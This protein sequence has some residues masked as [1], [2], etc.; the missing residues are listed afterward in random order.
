MYLFEAAKSLKILIGHCRRRHEPNYASW[1]VDWGLVF[2][3]FKWAV[4]RLRMQMY[5]VCVL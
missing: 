4:E 2:D 5:F 3:S 1:I